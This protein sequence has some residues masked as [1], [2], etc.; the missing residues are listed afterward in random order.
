MIPLNLA[1]WRVPG[2]DKRVALTLAA[3]EHMTRKG[4]KNNAENKTERRGGAR[5]LF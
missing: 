5:G 2:I 4:N 3:A 1:P